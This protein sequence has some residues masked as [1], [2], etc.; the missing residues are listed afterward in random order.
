MEK[1]AE[2]IENSS[3]P[4]IQDSL[5]MT[6]IYSLLY[7]TGDDEAIVLLNVLVAHDIPWNLLA[8]VDG[9]YFYDL[10]SDK[11]ASR[12][13]LTLAIRAGRPRLAREPLRLYIQNG[14]PI[15]DFHGALIMSIAMCWADVARQLV[16][17]RTT[18]P[19]LCWM[20]TLPYKPPLD[21]HSDIWSAM[22]DLPGLL[23]MITV[24]SNWFDIER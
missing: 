15:Q 20:T 22:L 14:V 2:L 7:Q 6:L 11:Y 3:D 24:A 9:T 23:P 13:A 1:V 4:R 8:P 10:K 16:D 21:L 19:E 18:K 5:G 17:L 12:S